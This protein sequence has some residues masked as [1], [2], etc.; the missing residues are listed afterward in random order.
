MKHIRCSGLLLPRQTPVSRTTSL[1]APLHDAWLLR[2]FGEM[3]PF[4][5]DDLGYRDL[6]RFPLALE[7]RFIA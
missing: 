5:F 1:S 2:T 3:R 6:A 7:R 4:D